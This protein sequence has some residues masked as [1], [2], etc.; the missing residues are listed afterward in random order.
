VQFYVNGYQF[1]KYVN[2]IGPQ[3]SFPV[4]ACF[5]SLRCAWDHANITAFFSARHPELQGQVHAHARLYWT[6]T[7]PHATGMNTLAVSLWAHD[8]GGAKLSDLH[9]ELRAK[10]ESAMPA[11]VNQPM[12]AWSARPGAY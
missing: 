7:C 8:A 12:P 5:P 10:I 2:A 4:R 1:G 11:V 3:T 6:L 9:V